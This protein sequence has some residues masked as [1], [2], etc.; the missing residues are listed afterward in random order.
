M[1]KNRLSY[2]RALLLS[3]LASLLLAAAPAGAEGPRISWELDDALKQIDRQANDFESAL[4]RV[5][6]ERKNREGAVLE[7]E[8]AT[9][10]FT[11]KGYVRM[12]VDSPRQRTYLIDDRYLYIYYPEREAVEQYS[13]S[14]HQ[15]RLEHYTRL[16]FSRSGKNLTDGFLL[17]SLGERDIGSSRTLGLD[18]TPEKEKNREVI[19]RIQLWIDQASWMPTQQVIDATRSGEQ[20]VMTYTHTARNLPLNPDLFKAKWPRGTKKTRM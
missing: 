1:N 17:T 15:D 8:T 3:T 13:L 12:D 16:G 18:M 10:F 19:S 20:L 9:I 7:E 5:A 14:K 6:L 2:S 4:A 11:K